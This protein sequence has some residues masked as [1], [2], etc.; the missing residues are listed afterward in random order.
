MCKLHMKVCLQSVI[1][2]YEFVAD[3]SVKSKIFSNTLVS[4]HK[5]MA[6][7]VPERM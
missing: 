7:A 1:R 2:T 4:L 5:V 3:N 6:Q